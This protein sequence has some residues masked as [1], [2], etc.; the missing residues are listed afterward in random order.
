MRRENGLDEGE[1]EELA[2]SGDSRAQEVGLLNLINTRVSRSGSRV[3][4]AVI[5]TKL[6]PGMQ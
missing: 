5:K 3:G 4:D 6:R 2:N 1:R